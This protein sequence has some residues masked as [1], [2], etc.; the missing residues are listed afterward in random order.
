M[1]GAILYAVFNLFQ[2]SS[3]CLAHLWDNSNSCGIL[4]PL[5]STWRIKGVVKSSGYNHVKPPIDG[6]IM[7]IDL[8]YHHPISISIHILHYLTTSYYCLSTWYLTQPLEG[9]FSGL[10][11]VAPGIP[12]FFLDGPFQ[13]SHGHFSQEKTCQFTDCFAKLIP[14]TTEYKSSNIYQ[15]LD[16][17][18]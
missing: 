5:K 13:S 18:W 8:G 11:H 6:N 10:S 9:S 16:P 12:R 17:F 15:Q 1:G 3:W 14:A 7:G 4:K 2:L